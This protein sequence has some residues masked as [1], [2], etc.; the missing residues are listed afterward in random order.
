MLMLLNGCEIQ[1]Q[2]FG[3][4]NLFSKII[5]NVYMSTFTSN[6]LY[7]KITS[8][9]NCNV[10]F[11]PHNVIFQYRITGKKISM[12]KIREWTLYFRVKKLCYF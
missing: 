6:L 8:E 3:Q 2:G 5:S 7:N 11:S 1:I 12:G 10:I 9:L 4:V